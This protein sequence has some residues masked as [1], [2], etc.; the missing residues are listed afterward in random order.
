[1]DLIL[2][3]D[4]M[5]ELYLGIARNARREQ[6][7]GLTQKGPIFQSQPFGVSLKYGL[8][9]YVGLLQKYSWQI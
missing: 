2:L 3:G 1:M 4:E 9:D 7:P 6:N 8:S 5:A